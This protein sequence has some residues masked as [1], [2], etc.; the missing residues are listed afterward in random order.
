MDKIIIIRLINIIH[1]VNVEF[2]DVF[3]IMF[4]GGSVRLFFLDF[5][6]I[7]E[8]GVEIEVMLFGKSIKNFKLFLGGEKLLIVIFLL[9]GIFKVRLFFLCIL[10]E[11]EVVLDEL[12]VV[13]YVEYL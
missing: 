1:D 11:V 12:N 13:R 8:S 3:V 6:N 7:L 9:F 5:K 2:N 10:D 4:G